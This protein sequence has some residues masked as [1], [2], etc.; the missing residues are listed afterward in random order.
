MNFDQCGPNSNFTDGVTWAVFRSEKSVSA[1]PRSQW[2]PKI[3]ERDVSAEERLFP[4]PLPDADHHGVGADQMVRDGEAEA[5]VPL[6]G[7]NRRIME[8]DA[9]A[10]P[11]R[12]VGAA[13]KPP[14]EP[15][16]LLAECGFGRVS[17]R[18]YLMPITMAS[19]PTR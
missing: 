7:G 17:T 3:S 11:V 13:G 16:M 2:I 9:A 12:D 6:P 4:A 8:H 10:K 19:G 14:Q 5:R 18:P 1:K 15:L